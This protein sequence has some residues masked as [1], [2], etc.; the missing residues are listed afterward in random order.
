MAQASSNALLSLI[1]SKDAEA[2]S[3]ALKDV[4]T[5]MLDHRSLFEAAISVDDPLVV[6]T[7]LAA[8]PALVLTSIDTL[9]STLV[10]RAAE[11]N[12]AAAIEL[13]LATSTMPPLL[14][15]ADRLQRLPLHLAVAHCCPDAVSVLLKQP[16]A[17]TML[18]A[19]DDLA[20]TPLDN[21]YISA[22][23]SGSSFSRLAKTLLPYLSNPSLTIDDPTRIKLET[24]ASAGLVEG[25]TSNARLARNNTAYRSAN[26]KD[27]FIP[28][29]ALFAAAK[30]RIEGNKG[31]AG[32]ARPASARRPETA[33]LRS[34]Q[35]E[36]V[37][38]SVAEATGDADAPITGILDPDLLLAVV[39]MKFSASLQQGLVKDFS[40]IYALIDSAGDGNATSGD[41]ASGCL[42][43]GIEIDE[44]VLPAVME[45]MTG[46]P[47]EE[48]QTISEEEF[49]LFC[50]LASSAAEQAAKAEGGGDGST[51]ES[52]FS[53]ATAVTT[54]FE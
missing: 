29:A 11:A 25:A 32:S 36:S 24:V 2:F 54:D 19:Q 34:H 52:G 17:V 5:Q 39:I 47:I 6:K 16:N 41:L 7:L 43:M 3:T 9:G 28:G 27:I 23:S 49:V 31:G 18:Q 20:R 12:S 38:A 21:Y 51:G 14:M 44:L 22:A 40:E 37:L 26:G 15:Q 33:R 42:A 30:E 35:S 10:H 13:F 50:E 1:F 53:G 46:R 8:S 45:R 4:G 48:A